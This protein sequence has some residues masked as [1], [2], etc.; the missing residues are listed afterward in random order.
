ML[1]IEIG[2]VLLVLGLAAFLAVK[3][4][5]SVVPIFLIVGLAL[6]KGGLLPLD[7]SSEFLETGAHFGAILLLLMLGLEHSAKDLAGAFTERRFVGLIDILVNGIP[8]AVVALLLGWGPV[9]AV[10]LGGITYVSSS[11]IASQMMREAGWQRSEISRRVTGILVFEDLALAPYLPLVT[12]IVANLG[13]ITGFVSVT[14]AV[15][16][17][18]VALLVALRGENAV[19]R[20]FNI[21]AP[22]GLLLTVFGGA[23][24]VAGVAEEVGFSSAVA[25]FLVGLVLTGEVAS[26]VRLRL[27]P[28]RD[29]FSAIFFL[30]FGLSIDPAEILSVWPLAL[31]LGLLGVAGKMYVGWLVAGDM[32]DRS[33]WRRAGAFLIPRGEFS[34]VIAGLASVTSFGSQLQAITV[35]Y[36]LI[37]SIAASLALRYFRSG[38][39]KI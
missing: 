32:S 25:A 36:V 3:I 13:A 12:T 9:G 24:F 38:F 11:G 14:S 18:A 8:G 10:V 27:S 20:L 30:F 35:T 21:Q 2:L 6:G 29:L 26:V 33:A 22:G 31:M 39:D 7:I 23:L 28:L 37:T 16:I 15:L 5:I 1:L 4:K 34:I 17:T 19:S